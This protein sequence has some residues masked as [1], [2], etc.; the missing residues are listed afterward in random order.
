MNAQD[1]LKLVELFHLL[2]LDVF[3]RKVDKRFYAV[4]GGCNLR[5]FL[6]A[7]VIQRIWIWTFKTSPKKSSRRP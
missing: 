5:F 6:K 4:K 7:F 2:F 3:G 1:T